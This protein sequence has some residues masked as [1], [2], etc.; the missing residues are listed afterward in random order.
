MLTLQ[1]TD[2]FSGLETD[3]ALNSAQTDQRAWALRDQLTLISLMHGQQPFWLGLPAI[4]PPGGY[5]SR[6]WSAGEVTR[7]G[8]PGI[9]GRHALD[10][11]ALRT[12]FRVV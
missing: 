10:P 1:S 2:A 12:D 11:K 9:V 5:S 6:V 8:I 7:L 3:E 4:S